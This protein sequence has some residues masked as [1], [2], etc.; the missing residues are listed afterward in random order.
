MT[1]ARTLFLISALSLGAAAVVLALQISMTPSA[2]E[3]LAVKIEEL[4]SSLVLVLV[5]VAVVVMG[6]LSECAKRWER[7]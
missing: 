4:R 3:F 5:A 6:V 1:P 2:W 7:E